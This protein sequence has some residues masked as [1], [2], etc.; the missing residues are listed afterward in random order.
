MTPTA[1]ARVIALWQQGLSHEAMAQALGIPLGTV[2]SRAYTLVRQ[3]KIKPRPRGGPSPTQKALAR[4]DGTPARAPA[5]PATPT[6]PAAERTDMHQWTVR[7][8]KALMDPLKAV[9]YAR[10]LPPRPVVEEL[11]WKA[12]TDHHLST[13][14]VSKGAARCRSTG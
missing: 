11:V 4:Q 7:R 2:S 8:S 10:R 9:A 5:P 6:T 12:L 3:G 1:E 14:E 13:P